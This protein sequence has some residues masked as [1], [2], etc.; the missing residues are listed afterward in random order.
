MYGMLNHIPICECRH[1]REVRCLRLGISLII[2]NI[3][4]C[5]VVFGLGP[6]SNMFITRNAI[7]T[8]NGLTGRTVQG[9][10]AQEA[11]GQ[12]S[13]RCPVSGAAV[14]MNGKATRPGVSPVVMAAAAPTD[15]VSTAIPQDKCPFGFGPAA[16]DGAQEATEGEAKAAECPMGFGSAKPKTPASA[17]TCTR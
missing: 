13:S 14:P 6:L 10:H 8:S 1:E 5:K 17:M 15:A 9:T 16:T 12:P 11:M 4:S 2:P 7:M 3:M